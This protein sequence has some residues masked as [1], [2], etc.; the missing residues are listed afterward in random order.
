M[1]TVNRKGADLDPLSW[2]AQRLGEAIEAL[3]RFSGLTVSTPGEETIPEFFRHDHDSQHNEAAFQCWVA[4]VV[5]RLGLE[6]ESVEAQYTEVNSLLRRCAPALLR[7]PGGSDPWFLVVLAGRKGRLSILG[8]NLAIERVSRE[9]VRRALCSDLEARAELGLD[10]LLNGTGIAGPRRAHART[11]L[12]GEFLAG[13]RVAAGWLMR[14]A[15]GAPLS[16]QVRAFRLRG[17]AMALAGAYAIAFILWILSW[18]LLGQGVL[19]G[20]LDTGWLTAWGLILLTL[21]PFRLLA[22]YAGGLLS[23]RAGALI[24]HRL[25]YG[26]LRLDPEEIRHQGAGQLLGCALEAET[27]EQMA[28]TGGFPG[29]DRAHRAG[30]V[31]CGAGSGCGRRPSPPPLALHLERGLRRAWLAVLS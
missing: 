13:E 12:L 30:L 5:A 17:P 4:H 28:V 16:R 8:P 15:G 21:L 6:A 27:V 31:H 20:H 19:A 9:A 22:S 14:P 3:G 23:I 26:A 18:G 11:A 29:R 24:K 7:L 10:T 1:T 2:P 25:L